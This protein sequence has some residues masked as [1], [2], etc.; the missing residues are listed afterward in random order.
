MPVENIIILSVIISA[1]AIFRRRLPT[2][3]VWRAEG[4]TRIRLNNSLGVGHCRS[5]V[6]NQRGSGSSMQ[7]EYGEHCSL[8]IGL[9]QCCYCQPG[10]VRMSGSL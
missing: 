10:T 3:T 4:L 2:L 9:Q 7:R 6:P 5:H 8:I 1:F